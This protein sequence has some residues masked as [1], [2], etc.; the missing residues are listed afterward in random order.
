MRLVVQKCL[1]FF[2]S[3]HEDTMIYIDVAT[4]LCR[5]LSFTFFFTK[6]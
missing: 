5:L 6:K 1:G 4:R 3:S 2:K